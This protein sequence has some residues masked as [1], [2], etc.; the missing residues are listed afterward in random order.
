[1]VVYRP[2][3][4]HARMV[5][6]FLREVQRMSPGPDRI[7]KVDVDTREGASIASLY[8]VMSYPKV[9]VL[10]DD[11]RLIQEWDA[12]TM[13]LLGDVR[14]YLNQSDRSLQMV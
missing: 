3:S 9:M 11:G 2:R 1:M 4:E 14:Y 7:E 10:A 12:G 8:D 5:D 6:D 13:P